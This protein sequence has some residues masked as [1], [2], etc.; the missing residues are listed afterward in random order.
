[1]ARS[2]KTDPRQH[3]SVVF[4]TERILHADVPAQTALFIL[5]EGDHVAA[6]VQQQ[7]GQ[8]RNS[9]SGQLR[10]LADDVALGDGVQVERLIGEPGDRAVHFVD[11]SSPAG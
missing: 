9:G 8:R 7:T 1:M 4:G 5:A 2:C 10:R 3:G 6:E 11:V